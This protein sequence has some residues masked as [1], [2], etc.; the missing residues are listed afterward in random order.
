MGF[1]P[2]LPTSRLRGAGLEHGIEL[3]LVQAV[4]VGVAEELLVEGVDERG[5]TRGVGAGDS[6]GRGGGAVCR[7]LLGLVATR[8]RT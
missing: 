3:V 6:D 4:P 1:H 7:L 8:A 2:P 5:T